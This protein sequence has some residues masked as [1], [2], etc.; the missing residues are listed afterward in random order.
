[1]QY[2]GFIGLGNDSISEGRRKMVAGH[3]FFTPILGKAEN[4]VS[5]DH[6]LTLIQLRPPKN[7]LNSLG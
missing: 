3:V 2:H 5:S 4:A 1:M 7:Q 6:P